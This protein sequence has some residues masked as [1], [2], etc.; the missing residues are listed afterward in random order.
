MTRKLPPILLFGVDCTMDFLA[1]PWSPTTQRQKTDKTCHWMELPRRHTPSKTHTCE[2]THLRRYSAAKTQNCED[3]ELRRH[4]TAKTQNCEDTELRRH[5]T[6]ENTEL[7]RCKA[8]KNF[9][10]HPPPKHG[11]REMDLRNLDLPLKKRNFEH[12]CMM[13]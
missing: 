3:T 7:R 11:I 2:G 10:E 6:N 12:M 9:T 4:R 13:L 1:I 5:R 8:A